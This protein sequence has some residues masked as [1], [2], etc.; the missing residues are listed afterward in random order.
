M[1]DLAEVFECVVF[2]AGRIGVGIFDPP[3]H[4][5]FVGLYFAGLAFA[6]GLNEFAGDDYGYA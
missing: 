2:G 1:R 4:F 5:Y 3:Y 6:L